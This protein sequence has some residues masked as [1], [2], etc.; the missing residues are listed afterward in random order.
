MVAAANYFDGAVSTA[1]TQ[2]N[3]VSGHID[4]LIHVWSGTAG[5]HFGNAMIQWK[6]DFQSIIHKLGDMSGVM[7]AN[8]QAYEAAHTTASEAAARAQS[9][10]D[11]TG[12]AGL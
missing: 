11:Q 1:T 5:A 4:E 3:S 7:R 8:A 6:S 12:L 2:L 10:I 9:Q